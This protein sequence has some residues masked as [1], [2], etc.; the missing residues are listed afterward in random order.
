MVRC[1]SLS[2]RDVD[3]LV[4]AVVAS[5]ATRHL[6]SDYGLPLAFAYLA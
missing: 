2:K 3:K 5:A 4:P 1:D 6:P